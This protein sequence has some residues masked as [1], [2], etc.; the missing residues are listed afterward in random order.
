MKINSFKIAALMFPLLSISNST[1]AEQINENH[2]LLNKNL[3]ESDKSHQED[4][5]ENKIFLKEYDSNLYVVKDINGVKSAKSALTRE[6]NST[7]AG[8]TEDLNDFSDFEIQVLFSNL[9]ENDI[10]SSNFK[11]A[12]SVNSEQACKQVHF[13]LLNDKIIPE[14]KDIK[15]EKATSCQYDIFAS[16][17]A[18]VST[19]NVLL[20]H[21]FK[22]WC[23]NS[24]QNSEIFNI[25]RNISSTCII[26]PNEIQDL[27]LKDMN[28]SDLSLLTGFINLTTLNLV[29]NKISHLPIGIFDK[30]T[31][32]KWIILSE[33]NLTHIPKETF[34]KL[35]QLEIL[36]LM[37]NKISS[38]PLGVF[39]HNP[40]LN[41]ISL[42]ENELEY[43]EPGV[44][45]K[46]VNLESIELSDNKFKIFPLELNNFT[47][48]VSFE[49]NDNQIS[50]IPENAFYN[51]KELV[52]IGIFGNKISELQSRIFQENPN[53]VFLNIKNNNL[54]SLPD[55]FFDNL[56]SLVNLDLSNNPIP[57]YP[58]EML[59][60][61]ISLELL[62]NEE[63]IKDTMLESIKFCRIN[64]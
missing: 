7:T 48:L 2:I 55:G 33:N 31:N 46:V 26:D 27:N 43:L 9:S 8:V 4:V 52:N 36:W 22:E 10:I 53:L 16:N 17:G 6:G 23:L 58:R 39:D 49:I 24:E 11:I 29:K 30:L 18:R 63:F 32:L 20:N 62:D 25:A 45:S 35:S 44:F 64:N 19:F 59:K 1:N 13:K 57:C 15:L 56:V 37:K 3:T 41:W 14:I 50:Q 51:N 34:N 28:I 12:P 42:Y 21:T 61:N 5:P 47:K 60:N 54:S 38:L 40:N